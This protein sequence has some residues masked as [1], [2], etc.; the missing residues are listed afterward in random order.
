MDLY[1]ILDL[2]SS[3]RELTASAWNMF[4]SVH[5]AILGGLFIIGRR[6]SVPERIVAVIVY[7]GFLYV[8]FRAQIDNYEYSASLIKEAVKLEK[9]DTIRLADK[10]YTMP[11]IVG[12][13]PLIYFFAL[14]CTV[15][16]IAFVNRISRN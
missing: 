7:V 6:I 9:Q 4:I 11:E 3:Q 5:I 10:I 16:T 8:N 13:L 2:I 12:A 1:H 15:A 14:I